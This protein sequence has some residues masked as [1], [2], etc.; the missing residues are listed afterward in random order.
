MNP[1]PPTHLNAARRMDR[2]LDEL[3][4]LCKGIVCDGRVSEK[5]AWFLLDWLTAHPELHR[6]PLAG[7]LLE[8][9][10]QRLNRAVYTVPSEEVLT[11]LVEAFTG[12]GWNQWEA[13]A[14]STALPF[15]EPVPKVA[16]RERTFCLTGR[17]LHG[18]RETC[19][20]EIVRRGGR[21]VAGVS[22]RLDYLLV[23]VAASRDWVHSC[24][25]RKIERAAELKRDGAPLVILSEINWA[26]Q[27]RR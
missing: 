17:F 7:P 6:H 10:E 15:D 16:H 27:L 26:D 25:G 8:R 9:F 1:T 21:V 14:L 13:T 22:R 19:E 11:D 23:G 12:D 24:F 4:G 5:E 2:D 3:I 18:D 20:A